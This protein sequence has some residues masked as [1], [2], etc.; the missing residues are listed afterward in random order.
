MKNR[1]IPLVDL[2]KFVNGTAA[3]RTEFVN[4][5][6]E[7]FHSIG[8]VGVIN[9]GIPKKLIDDFYTT[10]KRFFALPEAIKRQYEIPGM[11]GQRGYTS[12]GKEH[13]KQSKVADLKEFFQIGQ[14]VPANH[15]SKAEYPDNVQVVEEPDYSRLGFE[16]YR[17]FEKTGGYLLQAIAIHL[18]LPENYFQD[19]I[20]YGNSILRSIHYPPITRL[21]YSRRTTRRHQPDHL[22]GRCQRRWPG[23]PEHGKR[24]VAH[25]ARRRGNRDQRRRHV[26]APDQQLPQVHHPSRGQSSALGMALAAFVNPIFPAPGE[27]NGPELPARYRHRR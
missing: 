6:G 7:A 17:A 16:L 12:F 22:A 19:K 23:T 4:Q 14:E 21:G 20:T 24:M 11:A 25:C 1:S 13:A 18:N 10:S 5:L 8:F 9:H 15:P 27:Q 3:E 26:A 2:S